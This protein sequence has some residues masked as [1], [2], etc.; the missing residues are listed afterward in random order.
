MTQTNKIL[1]KRLK[2]IDKEIADTCRLLE[3]TDYNTKITE[4]QNK[5]PN[6]TGLVTTA[7]IKM[8]RTWK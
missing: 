4:I 7:T 8:Y 5:I 3:K 6:F 2:N 1:K